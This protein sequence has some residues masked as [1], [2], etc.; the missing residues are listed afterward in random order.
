MQQKL[1][2]QCKSTIIKT[3]KKTSEK[4]FN[5]TNV[6]NLPDKE[7]KITVIKKLTKLGRRMNEHSE[8][9]NKEKI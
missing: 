1:A 2:E 6:S 9:L 3:M 8:N 4:H 7:F 5:E